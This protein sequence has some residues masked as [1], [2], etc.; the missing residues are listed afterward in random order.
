MLAG[1]CFVL[2]I[3]A[4]YREEKPVMELCFSVNYFLDFLNSQDQLMVLSLMV[5]LSELS[6]ASIACSMGLQYKIY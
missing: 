1:L 5:S 6:K 3:A 2:K 4:S